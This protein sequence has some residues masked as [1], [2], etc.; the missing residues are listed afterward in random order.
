MWGTKENLKEL[1]TRYRMY[2][3]LSIRIIQMVRWRIEIEFD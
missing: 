3:K 2:S 1:R